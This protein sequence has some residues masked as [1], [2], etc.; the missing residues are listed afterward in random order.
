MF[1]SM[2]VC[3]IACKLNCQNIVQIFDIFNQEQKKAISYM[4]RSENLF[5]KIAL[6]LKTVIMSNGYEHYLHNGRN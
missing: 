2:L 1:H 6:N 4:K 3:Y 5:V